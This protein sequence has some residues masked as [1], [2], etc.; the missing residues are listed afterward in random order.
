[1]QT[2][3]S[4]G[5]LRRCAG[6]KLPFVGWL[7]GHRP[8][9]LRIT[10]FGNSWWWLDPWRR[11]APYPCIFFQPLSAGASHP[12]YD[13]Q[14]RSRSHLRVRTGWSLQLMAR[15]LGRT[16]E[17]AVAPRAAPVPAGPEGKGHRGA[18]PATPR[19]DPAPSLP[20]SLFHVADQGGLRLPT[21]PGSHLSNYKLPSL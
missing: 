16:L 18:R 14:E 12:L 15:C 9:L 8:S 1:M 11:R 7:A 4:A 21:K 10:L 13:P 2:G 5:T 17:E 19:P 6:E 20:S 3:W